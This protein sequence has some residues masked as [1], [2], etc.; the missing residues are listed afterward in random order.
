MTAIHNWWLYRPATQLVLLVGLFYWATG[1]HPVIA[2]ILG[3]LL[4]E[5]VV[6]AQGRWVARFL[7]AWVLLNAFYDILTSGVV[8]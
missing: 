2:L 8:L 5:F 1:A 6:M 4:A 3:P 7:I